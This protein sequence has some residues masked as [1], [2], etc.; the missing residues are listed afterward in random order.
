M[1]EKWFLYRENI[2]LKNKSFTRK[3]R[4][5]KS[6]CGDQFEQGRLSGKM[7]DKTGNTVPQNNLV[8]SIGRDGKSKLRHV[9]CF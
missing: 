7:C 8:S 4:S 1:M 6:I 5:L 2:A 3:S 9:L